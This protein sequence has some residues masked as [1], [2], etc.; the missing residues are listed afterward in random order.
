MKLKLLISN[1]IK[2]YLHNANEQP[3]ASYSTYIAERSVKVH[4]YYE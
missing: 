3:D 4:K 1:N 2:Y